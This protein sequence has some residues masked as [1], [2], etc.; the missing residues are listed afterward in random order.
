LKKKLSGDE[1]PNLKILT[2]RK[3]SLYESEKLIKPTKPLKI[4]TNNSS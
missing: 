4:M 1:E 2:E 3:T